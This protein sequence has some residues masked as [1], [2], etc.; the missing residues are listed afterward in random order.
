MISFIGYTTQ[1]VKVSNQATIHVKLVEDAKALEEVV[2]I[3]LMVSLD[4]KQV[5]SAITSLK[6]DDLM[7]GVERGGISRRPCKAR[8]AVW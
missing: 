5:T 4:K 1:E 3:G 7:V 8:S 6:A 2:V